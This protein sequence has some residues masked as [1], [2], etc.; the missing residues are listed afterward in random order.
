MKSNSSHLRFGY[1]GVVKTFRCADEIVDK[2]ELESAFLDLA[3]DKTSST[4]AAAKEYVVPPPP[5]PVTFSPSRVDGFHDVSTVTVDATQIVLH[6][7]SGDHTHSFASIGRRQESRIASLLKRCTFRRPWPQMVANRSWCIDPLKAYFVFFTD[8][9]VTLYM[10][11]DDVANYATCCFSRIR[12][13][14]HSGS[15]AT[16]D[17]N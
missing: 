1:G 8:P 11:S 15:Y 10:P 9:T 16:F 13:I 14:I 17:L 3:D 6:T 5:H 7:S 2:S 4:Q 12:D